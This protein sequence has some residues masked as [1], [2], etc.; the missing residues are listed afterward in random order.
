[1][2]RPAKPTWCP[3][4][5]IRHSWIQRPT[6]LNNFTPP[7]TSCRPRILRW[8]ST[9]VSPGLGAAAEGRSQGA[10]ASSPYRSHRAMITD[11]FQSIVESTAV[12]P[13][14]RVSTCSINRLSIWVAS[15]TLAA[16]HDSANLQNRLMSF[17]SSMEP[18]TAL[19]M[20][21][22]A[23]TTARHWARET[24]TLI[25]LRSKMKASPRDPYSP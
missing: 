23:T 20:R 25:L 7:W 18:A 12:H 19:A 11:A 2:P 14:S 21:G 6:P 5:A 15:P 8:C 9:P 1:M 3:L 24:A 13:H 16:A 10:A 17:I 22:S 4:M